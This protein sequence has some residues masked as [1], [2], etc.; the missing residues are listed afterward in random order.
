MRKRSV[1]AEGVHRYH[2]VVSTN[3]AQR[4]SA[5]TVE[6][7]LDFTFRAVRGVV[8]IAEYQLADGH[9]AEGDDVLV[10]EGSLVVRR[11][12]A[13]APTLNI[14]TTKRI[15]F[16]RAFG[17]EA[18]AMI[19]CQMGYADFVRELFFR[20]AACEGAHEHQDALPWQAVV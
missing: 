17:G 4:E 9:P 3:C 7:E 10:D 2:E 11:V 16:N 8:A 12:D 20:C 13:G 19:M 18:L 14:T 1:S 5:W 6:A 15:K